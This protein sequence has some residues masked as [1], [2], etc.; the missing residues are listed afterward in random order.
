MRRF[1]N[2]NGVVTLLY[3]EGMHQVISDNKGSITILK[4]ND[5]LKAYKLYQEVVIDLESTHDSRSNTMPS[6]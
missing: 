1:K 4:T 3:L 2:K 5:E 6:P